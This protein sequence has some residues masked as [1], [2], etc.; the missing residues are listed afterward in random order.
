MPMTCCIGAG[1]EG[2]SAVGGGGGG[3]VGGESRVGGGGGDVDGNAAGRRA[4]MSGIALG[5]RIDMEGEG[6]N[7]VVAKRSGISMGDWPWS[8]AGGGSAEECDSEGADSPPAKDGLRLGIGC[9]AANV[10]AGMAVE[11]ACIPLLGL[12]GEKLFA[13]CGIAGYADSCRAAGTESLTPEE[14]SVGFC[15]SVLGG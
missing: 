6:M 10:G 2:R 12:A 14:G 13:A 7:D 4:D 11:D 1:G 8:E 5:D 15:G 9:E 3:D